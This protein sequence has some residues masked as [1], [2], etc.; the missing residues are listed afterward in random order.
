MSAQP[1]FSIL[2]LVPVSEGH[3]G[4]YSLARVADLAQL[5][6]ELGFKRIWYAEHHG[7]PAIAS[8]SPEVLIAHAAARTSHIQV[9]SGGVMLPNHVPLRIVETY[10]TLAALYP[11]RIDLGIGR[12]GGTDSKT[13]R[14]LHSFGGEHFSYQVAEMLGYEEGPTGPNHPHPNITA[15]PSGTDLPPIWVLGSSGASAE[16][17]GGYG[18]GYGFAAH[19]SDT[20]A[21][22]AFDAYRTAFKPSAAFPEPKTILCLAVVCAETEEEA[23]W[24]TWPVKLNWRNLMLGNPQPLQSPETASKFPFTPAEERMLEA[25]MNLIISGTPEQVRDEIQRRAGDTGADEVMIASTLYDHAT[26]L[27]S[28]RLLAK[29]LELKPPC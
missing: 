21:K 28:Y 17:A 5:G 26:R 22:P 4:A 29:A 12:A 14:A 25:R 15:I 7:M 27:D 1:D 23:A 16:F 19:F 6:D 11:N 24:Q 20:P 8:S 13:L 9:G 18:F 2:D 10:R 3:N